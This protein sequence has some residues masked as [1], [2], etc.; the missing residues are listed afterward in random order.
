V[1]FYDDITT[2]TS[3]SLIQFRWGREDVQLEDGI[4]SREGNK[5][6]DGG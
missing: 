3:Y 2:S 4:F 5:M 1:P 6:K